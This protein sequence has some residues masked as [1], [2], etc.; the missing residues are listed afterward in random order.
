MLSILSFNKFSGQVEG[1]NEI[2]EHYEEKYGPGN[3][4]PPVKTSIL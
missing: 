1:M 3:Y 2:Q 4:I